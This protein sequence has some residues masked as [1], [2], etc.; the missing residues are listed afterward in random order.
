LEI[1]EAYEEDVVAKKL[2]KSL[3]GIQYIDDDPFSS[4]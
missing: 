2:P 4:V 1:E 3:P